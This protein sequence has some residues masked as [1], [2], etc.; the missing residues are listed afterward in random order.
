MGKT[1][2]IVGLSLAAI[3]GAAYTLS[4]E[5]YEV[6][7]E[8]VIDARSGKI[9]KYLEDLRRWPEWSAW[10][11]ENDPEISHS[12]SGADKGVDAR[13]SWTSSQGPGSMVITTSKPDTGLWY[14][15]TFGEPGKEMHSKGAFQYYQVPEGTKVVWTMAGQ[16][17]GVIPRLMGFG[18]DLFMGPSFE[19]GLAGLKRV[20]EGTE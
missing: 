17:E 5:R 15:L 3:F 7:R 12:Y 9:H 16:L 20:A 2:L 8:I 18:M 14:D 10:T 11:A 6:S 4:P 13:S 19:E 1:L